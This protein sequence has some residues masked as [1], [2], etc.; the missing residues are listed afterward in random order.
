MEISFATKDTLGLYVNLVMY[1]NIIFFVFYINSKIMGH[2]WHENYT[3]SSKYSC[4]KCADIHYNLVLT[5]LLTI[6][7]FISLTI[8][9][10]SQIDNVERKI[11]KK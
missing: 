1:I 7:T 3:N 2:F 5:I 8:A 6:W 9:L 11:L 4:S 10:R